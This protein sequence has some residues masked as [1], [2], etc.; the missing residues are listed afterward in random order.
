[1]TVTC[2]IS[3]VGYSPKPQQNSVLGKARCLVAANWATGNGVTAV[4]RCLGRF[5]CAN[6]LEG[7]CV[8]PPCRIVTHATGLPVAVTSNISVDIWVYLR[9][10][11]AGV[12]AFV[13]A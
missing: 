3:S 7:L 10:L 8:Q 6:Q 9:A 5:G 2:S 13:A 1:M 12:C 11:G 4:E